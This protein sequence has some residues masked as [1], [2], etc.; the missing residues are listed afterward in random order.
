[1]TAREIIKEAIWTSSLADIDTLLSYRR[2]LRQM[3]DLLTSSSIIE[4][5][6]TAT[7]HVDKLLYT[8][9]GI[10]Q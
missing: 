3:G 10:P 4:D 2:K 9:F 5:W 1:M 6:N 8:R 7:S